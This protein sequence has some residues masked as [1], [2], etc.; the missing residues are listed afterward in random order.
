MTQHSELFA[1]KLMVKS[2]KYSDT[3]KQ[4]L[5]TLL[6]EMIEAEDKRCTDEYKAELQA[7]NQSIDKSL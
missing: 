4:P 7:I 1:I 2:L 6:Q 5:L 3:Y